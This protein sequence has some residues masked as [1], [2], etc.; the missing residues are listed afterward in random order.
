M[1]GENTVVDNFHL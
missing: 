1:L